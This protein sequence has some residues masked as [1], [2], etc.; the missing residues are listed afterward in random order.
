MGCSGRAA[1]APAFTPVEQQE[2]FEQ[3]TSGEV[4]RLIEMEK[5]F[6]AKHSQVRQMKMELGMD[7]DKPAADQKPNSKAM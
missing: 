5:K 2:K 1:K 7:P 3:E 6:G 4:K